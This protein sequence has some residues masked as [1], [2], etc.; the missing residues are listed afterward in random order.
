MISDTLLELGLHRVIAECFVE[1][2]ASAHVL[3]KLGMRKEAHFLKNAWKA[4]VWRDTYLYALLN[5]EWKSS[6]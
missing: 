2:V 1:Q 5:D 4:C 6:E 3:E